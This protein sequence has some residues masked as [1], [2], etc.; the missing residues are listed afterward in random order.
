MST[1]FQLFEK[2]A[3]RAWTVDGM[4]SN[5]RAH[6][7]AEHRGT[8]RSMSSIT[9]KASVALMGAAVAMASSVPLPAVAQTN[10]N[11]VHRDASESATRAGLDTVPSSFWP[12]AIE[13]L[14]AST[15]IDETSN[16]Y[17]DID[18]AF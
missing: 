1:F 7:A 10:L 18:S 5:V 14:R 17:V 2:F 4:V 15:P 6:E 13:R 9:K 11:W 12:K 8:G 3:T 16:H